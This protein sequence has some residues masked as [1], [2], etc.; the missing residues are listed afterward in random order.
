[1]QKTTS[2]YLLPYCLSRPQLIDFPDELQAR[3]IS[4]E[5]GA[6]AQCSLHRS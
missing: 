3:L 2:K 6:T 1:M 5:T 4:P